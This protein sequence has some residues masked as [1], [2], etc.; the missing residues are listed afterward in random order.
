[1]TMIAIYW[2]FIHADTFLSS[3]QH[4]TKCQDI[5]V[6]LGPFVDLGTLKTYICVI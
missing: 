3:L 5:Y 1:M 2:N 6:N 4:L